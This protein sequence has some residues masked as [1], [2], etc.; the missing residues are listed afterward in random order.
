MFDQPQTTLDE[1]VELDKRFAAVL[2]HGK[3]LMLVS[4]KQLEDRG[5]FVDLNVGK[6]LQKQ[7]GTTT[8]KMDALVVSYSDPAITRA[9]NLYLANHHMELLIHEVMAVL[10]GKVANPFKKLM[11]DYRHGYSAYLEGIGKLARIFELHSVDLVLANQEGPQQLLGAFGTLKNALNAIPDLSEHR[12][13]LERSVDALSIEIVD[14]AASVNSKIKE[15][16]EEA[17]NLLKVARENFAQAEIEYKSNLTAAMYFGQHKENRQARI[18]FLDHRIKQMNGAISEQEDKL[19]EAQRKEKQ[20]TKTVSKE[21]SILGIEYG[22]KHSSSDV[23]NTDWTQKRCKARKVELLQEKAI[24]EQQMDDIVNM[25]QSDETSVKKITRVVQAD[26]RHG[27][28][29][30]A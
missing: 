8:E 12:N 11:E 3:Q 4:Q 21:I 24:L 2:D 19:R 5:K 20:T 6:L 23:V 13:K 22:F 9:L 1:I 17:A 16:L 30:V 29:K 18:N 26:F 28:R 10:T 27:K 25:N 14:L 7:R 15:L